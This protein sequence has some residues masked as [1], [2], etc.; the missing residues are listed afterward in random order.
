[1]GWLMTRTGNAV[2]FTIPYLPAHSVDG[3]HRRLA[4]RFFA[5][6]GLELVFAQM[7]CLNTSTQN[8]KWFGLSS[9]P[10]R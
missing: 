5:N 6:E 10:C 9:D 3:Y 8:L 2:E 1:M 4:G 7:S